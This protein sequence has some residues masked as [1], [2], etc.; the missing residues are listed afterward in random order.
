MLTAQE[1]DLVLLS[2]GIAVQAVALIVVPGTAVAYV[3]ARWRSRWTWPLHG[4]V[5]LPLVMPP[6]VTGYVLLRCLG[7][8]SAIGR[9]FE[10]LTRSSLAY[11]TLA[12]VL[13]AAVM[14][15]PLY[16]Q[17]VRLALLGVDPRLEHVS[18]TLG[19][20]AV[21]TMVRVTL[22]LALPGMIAGAVFAFARALGEF[23]ATMVFAGNI[24]G[25]TRQIPLAVFTL[26]S[27]PGG[28]A[29]AWR[30]T[31]VSVLASFACLLGVSWLGRST[32]GRGRGDA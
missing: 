2:L 20:G 8:G 17:S 31:A 30:L 5:M 10:E 13:A 25:E 9:A 16:V 1:V 14:A 23:G 32:S 27:S 29:A 15:F 19:R 22:P 4:L 7:R 12:C 28:D 11:S 18:R 6:V 21:H 24:P 26:L 3:L